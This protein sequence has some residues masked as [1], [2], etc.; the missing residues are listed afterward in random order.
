M[1][2]GNMRH[3]SGRTLPDHAARRHAILK[4]GLICLPFRGR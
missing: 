2:S 1:V 3:P 4:K